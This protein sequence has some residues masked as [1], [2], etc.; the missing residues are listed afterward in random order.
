VLRGSRGAEGGRQRRLGDGPGADL[1]WQ[2][3][4]VP[5]PEAGATQLGMVAPMLAGAL[6][7][8]G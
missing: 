8:Q 6:Q 4:R 5:K 1:S 7:R 2:R 3:H